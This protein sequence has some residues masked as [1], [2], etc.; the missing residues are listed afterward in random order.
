M[1][2]FL[3]QCVISLVLVFFY[4]ASSLRVMSPK[5]LS[6]M[7]QPAGSVFGICDVG[8][9]RCWAVEWLGVGTRWGRSMLGKRG[10]R[11][12]AQ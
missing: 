8:E 4:S 9:D 6:V 3:V 10:T 2:N 5:L 11:Y 12:A 7:Q 1:E